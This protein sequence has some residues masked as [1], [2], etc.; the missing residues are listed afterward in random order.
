MRDHDLAALARADRF[1]A[2]GHADLD[3]QPLGHDHAGVDDERRRLAVADV[4]RLVGDDA[5]VRRRVALHDANARGAAG[6]A[7]GRKQRTAR[8]QRE[9]DGQ[10]GPVVPRR[11]IEQRAEVV[12]RAAVGVGRELAD[13]GDLQLGVA[14][15]AREHAAAERPR[16]LV[17]YEPARRQ[18]V[19]ERVV[20]RHPGAD[21]G[22]VQRAGR[23]PRVDARSLRLEHRP[24]GGE[25]ARAAEA[26][27][28]DEA[29]ERRRLALRG[30]QRVLPEHRQACEGGAVRDGGEVVSREVGGEPGQPARRGLQPLAEAL[31]QGGLAR[32]R[33]TRLEGVEVGV[34]HGRHGS[35]S[36]R[37]PPASRRCRRG[38]GRQASQRFRRL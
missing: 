7:H 16:A 23:G 4:R 32:E 38:P 9:A 15:A 19:G 29:A 31:E 26:C 21:A 3:D 11:V 25:H 13:R 30:H 14:D 2:S 8:D 18:V 28:V 12:R 35:R 34:A 27:G 10:I 1:A 20:E 22:G 33:V 17:E 37:F 5:G 6:L 24:R 36:D